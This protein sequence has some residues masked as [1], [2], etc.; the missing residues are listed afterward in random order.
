MLRIAKSVWMFS[1][2]TKW[3]VQGGR[4]MRFQC[5]ECL[6]NE[7]IETV[8][9]GEDSKGEFE[10]FECS[11]CHHINRLYNDVIDYL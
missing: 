7:Y 10:D 5:E 4:I 9:S 11:E 2:N 1:K 6:N 3:L 8:G